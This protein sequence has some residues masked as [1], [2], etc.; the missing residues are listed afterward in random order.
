MRL[1]R[2]SRCSS[3]SGPSKHS[4][5]K[6][7]CW[8]LSRRRGDRMRRGGIHKH[9]RR[10]SVLTLLARLVAWPTIVLAQPHGRKYRIG[11][12]E[13]ISQAENSENFGALI[14]GLAELGYVEGE[15]VEFDIALQGV[16]RSF[17]ANS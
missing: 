16:G 5:R 17:L 4:A 3:N 2:L 15:N 1:I 11:V 13:T 6:L 9:I 12:L 8:P 14:Q 7:D 10:R